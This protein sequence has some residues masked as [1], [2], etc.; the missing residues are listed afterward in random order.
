MINIGVDVGA[1]TIK[2]VALQ[3]GTI[4]GKE[5]GLSGFEARENARALY[6]QVLK[7]A[8]ISKDQIK[9]VTATGGGRKE[10]RISSDRRVGER[11][12]TVRT[13]LRG[14]AVRRSMDFVDFQS[15]PSHRPVC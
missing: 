10:V 9:A 3:D 2:I 7:N 6:D 5:Q 14:A 8:G 11:R 13:Q 12:G 4:V 1:K 15:I